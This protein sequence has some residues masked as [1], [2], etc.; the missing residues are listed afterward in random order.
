MSKNQ[1]PLELDG[2]RMRQLVELA[3]ER[4]TH[5]IETLPEQ[6]AAVW[7]GGDELARSLA[8]PLPQEGSDFEELLELLFERVIPH[9]F[10][11]ASPG[12]VA[13][14]PGGGLFH[15]A[16]A[17]LISN[18]T[19]R[20]VGVWAAAPGL[21]Q[22]EANVVRWYCEMLGYGP[23]SGGLLTPGGSVANLTAIT[24]ARRERLGEDFLDGVVYVSE[25]T[26]HSVAKSA[27]LAG[28]RPGH[29]R[30]V[31]CDDAFRLRFDD[32]ERQ[33]AEDR[34]AGLR[35]AILAATGGTTNSGA[36]DDLNAAAD[37]AEREEL[38]LH[39]DAAY[40][41][42]FVLTERGRQ[43]LAGI[44]RADS[45]TLD[46]HKGLFLP[47]GNGS[48]MVRDASALRRTHSA[49]ADYLPAMQ[50]EDELVDFC[51]ISP[52]LSR[53]FR[54]LRAW[55]PLKMHGVDVFRQALDEKLDL[56]QYAA[57]E[58]ATIPGIRIVAE[59]Q[60]SLLVFALD[61][62]GLSGEKIDRLNEEL[63]DRINRRRRVFLTS[64]RL[65]GRFVLRICVLSFR[66]HR[67][68]M[69]MCMADVRDSVAELG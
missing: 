69:E 1:Y 2:P 66:T 11:T 4:I 6:P 36:V 7:E 12:Y 60:L 37:L 55:L 28:F 64:A 40:G 52:E 68:R 35:P 24:T 39:V 49:S 8:E 10:N 30:R 42:F 45:I 67:D 22:L 21:A 26:H 15:S 53:D 9:S 61:R 50:E 19:N 23:G 25:Q 44:E 57:T 63:L 16:V 41:G 33:I 38:W 34:R 5:H 14:V 65:D 58:L 13:F 3:M 27:V 48:L 46:P 17:D 20:F 29:V 47:Y 31:A 18:A 51:E 56:A 43:A 62:P 32:L 59:P 54:G